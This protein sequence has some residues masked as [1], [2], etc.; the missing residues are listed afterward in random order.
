MLFFQFLVLKS[1]LI[2][3]KD[4]FQ[5]PKIAVFNRYKKAFLAFL[6]FKKCFYR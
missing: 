3:K 1:F 5:F 4:V 2:F 6:R